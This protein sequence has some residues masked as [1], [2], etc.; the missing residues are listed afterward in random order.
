MKKPVPQAIVNS[1]RFVEMEKCWWAGGR[2]GRITRGPLC[3]IF[4][5]DRDITGIRKVDFPLGELEP[6]W[7]LGRDSSRLFST[8]TG[9]IMAR[10]RSA[11]EMLPAYSSWPL[12]SFD[13]AWTGTVFFF[14]FFFAS[15]STSDGRICFRERHVR[16]GIDT[17]NLSFVYCW[18]ICLWGRRLTVRDSIVKGSR[19]VCWIEEILFYL[20]R[21]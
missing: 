20:F 5:T 10:R 1:S 16:L 14:F 8:S 15:L 11:W 7:I 6:S 3:A 18:W 19:I 9:L 17:R 12:L 13:R 21:I 2:E 4:W